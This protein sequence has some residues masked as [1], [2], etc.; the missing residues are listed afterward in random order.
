MLV[1]A[2]LGILGALVLPIYQGHASE[3]K[4]SSAKSNLHAMRA[5]IELY[6]LQHQGSLPGYINGAGAPIATMQI[7]LTG[8][9]TAS[10]IASSNKAPLGPFVC[11]PY[12]L[13]IPM[14]PYNNDPNIAYVAEATTFLLAADGTSSG[15]LYKKETGEIRL[16]YPGT[17]EDGIAYI[18]Y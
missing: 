16:N 8:T 9:S 14:N 12:L 3:A 18:E 7:Q 11:G 2:I 17:D 1:V 15:W 6:R 13:K 4:I 10:G 5:Q